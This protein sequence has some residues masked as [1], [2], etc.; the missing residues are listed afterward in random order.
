MKSSEI[1]QAFVLASLG[2][3]ANSTWATES[4][5]PDIPTQI[6]GTDVVCTGVSLDARQDIRWNA[7]ALKVE[8]AGPGGQYVGDEIV[9]VRRGNAELLNVS[10]SGPW[11]LLKLPPGR[12]E[13]SAKAEGQVA[14]S[15]AFAPKEGQG[16]IILRFPGKQ[17]GE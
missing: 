17:L 15:P 4:L 1:L 11:L 14:A 10:C 12:Y 5:T 6:N 8:F 16:R 9:S 2:C 3:V 7:Y 13:V